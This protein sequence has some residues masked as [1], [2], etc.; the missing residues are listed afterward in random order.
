MNFLG[1]V[2]EKVILPPRFLGGNDDWRSVKFFY[3]AVNLQWSRPEIWK[4]FECTFFLIGGIHELGKFIL[5]HGFPWA[6]L[7]YR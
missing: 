7:W 4:D 5:C 1:R 2:I 3:C 6:L